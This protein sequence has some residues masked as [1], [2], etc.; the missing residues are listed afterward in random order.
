MQRI[1]RS[2]LLVVAILLHGAPSR[3]VAQ[4][5]VESA[6]DPGD[7]A[8]ATRACDQ[9]ESSFA[10]L[11]GRT[12]PAGRIEISDSITLF[13]YEQRAE[14]WR[15]IWPSSEQI[16]IRH[17]SDLE[18]SVEEELAH[19]WQTVLPHEIGHLMLTRHL[20]PV[21]P[22][23]DDQYG[24][25]LPDWF[26]EAVAVW[27]EPVDSREPEY[28]QMRRTS[29][30]VP[31]LKALLEWTHPVV[32]ADMGEGSVEIVVHLPCARASECPGRGRWDETMEVRTRRFLDGD[33]VVDTMYSAAPL[34]AENPM[35]AY[36]YAYSAALLRYVIG[37]GGT[38]ALNELLARWRV[39][40]HVPDPLVGLPGLPA[41]AEDLEDDWIRWFR[42]SIL[43]RQ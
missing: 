13:G 3:G 17:G 20:G 4:C 12:S 43:R 14:G 29:P 31:D 24:T 5:V 37:N 26:D 38:P 35:D 32:K 7:R 40:P 21:R 15:M 6:G 10:M 25:H 30:F 28:E 41:T 22:V 2:I 19:Q 33:V 39:N 9:A 42:R 11:F 1:S 34:S 27:M 16:R 8:L 36:F 18:T 23:S